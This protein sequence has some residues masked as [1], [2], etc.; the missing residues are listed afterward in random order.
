MSENI[1]EV[2]DLHVYYGNIGAL[3]GI[4][5]EV[6]AGEVVSILGANGAGKTTTLRSL[7]GL[8]K[9]R[10]GQIYFLGKAIH[11]MPAHRIVSEGVVQSPEGRLVFPHLSVWENLELGAYTRK[12]KNEFNE[13]IQECFQLFPRLKERLKQ[14]AGTLSGG[15][16]QMLAIARALMAKPKLL[17]LDE[18]SLGIAPILV[19][20]IFDAIKMINEKGVTVLVVEQNA[21]LALRYSHRAYVLET[22]E[23]VLQ[24]KASDLLQDPKVREAYL[25]SS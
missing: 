12:D 1:L 25:G 8:E 7:S 15:E 22:G 18:P 24:G 17:L 9:P 10:Q 19:Q 21:N 3:R 16:Q 14:L 5:L 20:A 4:N 13:T 2:K 6:K 11:D 23:M